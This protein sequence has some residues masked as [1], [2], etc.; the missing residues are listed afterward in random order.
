[1]IKSIERLKEEMEFWMKRADEG[2]CIHFSDDGL[3]GASANAMLYY[4]CGRDEKPS[5]YPRDES[6]WGRCQRTIHTIPFIDWLERIMKLS[7]M[8]YWKQFEKEIVIETSDRIINIRRLKGE[9]N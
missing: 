3:C 5:E 6:D 4:A 8:E 1:M 9:Y 7:E 2:G